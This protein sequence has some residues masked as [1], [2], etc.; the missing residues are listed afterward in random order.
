MEENSKIEKEVD[1]KFLQKVEEIIHNNIAKNSFS[2]EVLAVE[3]AV[4]TKTLSRKIK[5]LTGFTPLQFIN[6]IRLQE[7]HKILTNREKETVAEVMY[8]V[9]FVSGGH[10]SK[11]FS[12]RFG[13]NPSEL[14]E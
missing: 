3:M 12:K 6:E 1:K 4:S 9:G 2:V 10:F 14:I 8:A 13:K 7:A 11:L 5:P